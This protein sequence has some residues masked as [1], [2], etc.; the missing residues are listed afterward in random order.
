M[1]KDAT[2]QRYIK[3]R[4]VAVMVR[5]ITQGI[6]NDELDNVFEGSRQ[7]QYQRQMLFSQLAITMAD[8]VLGIE[9]SPHQAYKSHREDLKVVVSSFYDKLNHVET[10]VS[11]A[12][13]RHA[14]E[15]ASAL[16]DN[17]GFV[18]SEPIPGY[19]ARAIDGNHLQ[20]TEKRIDGLRGLACAALP[21]TVVATYE[22]GR[23]LFDRAYLLEDAHAQEATVLDRVL[24][25]MAAK[26]LMIGDRHFCIVSFL[27]GIDQRDAAFVIRQHGRLKGELQGKRRKIGR[28]ATGMVYEQKLV[29]ARTKD[30]LGMT[31][32]RVTVELD[33]PTRDGDTE[34][35]ILTNVPSSDADARRIAE[36][37]R[38]RWEIE[39]GFYVLT[40]TMTCEVKSLGHPLAAL[41][42][43]CTAMVGY[44][45]T[46]VLM[47]ALTKAHGEEEVQE[48]SAYSLSREIAKSSDG[49]QVTFT[50]E[51]WEALVPSVAKRQARFLIHV[52]KHVDL[53]RHRKS[54]RGPKKQPPK[55]TGYKNGGHLSTAKVLAESKK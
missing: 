25:D 14:Y 15:K 49:L 12:M 27:F 47:T 3:L 43:F 50:E 1:R 34:I 38:Q 16:Q 42:V 32:R 13:V 18:P 19:H 40:T 21:G 30:D 29:I 28:I 20:K 26:D 10:S 8:V 24:E 48:L 17:L 33:E 54:R 39:N 5:A 4:P 37:Y 41:F 22:L 46:R 2:L 7:R 6:L 55:R 52:A 44:N 45:G 51:E 53:K 31:V 35:H 23:E 9:D 11:E 36:L